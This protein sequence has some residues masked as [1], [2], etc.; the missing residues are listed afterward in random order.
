M[1]AERSPVEPQ[2]PRVDAVALARAGRRLQ[3]AG[4]V[5]WL[6]EEVAR[7]MA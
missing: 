4:Q 3:A 7:R 2:G 1:Q 6:H 5:P